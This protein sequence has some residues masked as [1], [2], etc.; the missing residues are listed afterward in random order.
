MPAGEAPPRAV[1][2]YTF[3]GDTNNGEQLERVLYRLVEQAGRKLRD[4]RLAARRIGVRMDYSD[5]V[6]RIRSAGLRP[7]SAN[8]ITLFELA[9]AVFRSA[10]Q[11][12]VRIRYLRLI[13][14]RLTFPPAQPSLF[15]EERRAE[16]KR[17]ALVAALDAVRDRFGGDVVGWGRTMAA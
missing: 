2:E 16:E 17:T 3:E 7:A 12:R 8:D 10:W 13:C 1:A 14:D 11:R 9:L 6:R 15:M 5:G 4:R